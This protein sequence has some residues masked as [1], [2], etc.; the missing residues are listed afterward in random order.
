MKYLNG[1]WSTSIN[2]ISNDYF[3]ILLNN[4]WSA[5]PV[6][7]STDV[8]YANENNTLFVTASDMQ[9]LWNP[10]LKDIAIDFASDNAAFLTAF[11]TGWLKMMNSDRFDGPTG[12]VCSNGSE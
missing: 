3:Q 5:V 6:P 9:L 12:N 10:V 7:G 2:T 11:A 4:T 8:Q 1:T